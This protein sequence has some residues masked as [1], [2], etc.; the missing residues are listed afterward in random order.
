MF[1]FLERFKEKRQLQMES[2]DSHKAELEPEPNPCED[3]PHISLVELIPRAEQQLLRGNKKRFSEHFSYNLSLL[4]ERLPDAGLVCELFKAGTLSKRKIALVYLKNRANPGI[5][6]EIKDRIKAIKAETILD[7]SYVER[8]LEN[9]NASPFPQI[10]TTQRPDI[11]ESALVQGR[12]AIIVEGSPD[13]MLAP[14]TFFDLMDTPDDA[15]RRWYIAANFFRLARYIMFL[16]AA[17]LPGFYIAMTSYN[18]EMIP[19]TLLFTILASREGTPFP[20][21]FETFLMMGVVE[22]VRMMMIRIP[23]QVGATIALLTGV[24]LVGA[25]LAAN[26]I[27]APVV[28]IVTLTVISSFAIPN[29]DLRSSVRIIQ[30]FTM[31]MSSFL[32]IFGFAASFFYIA[33]HLVTLKSFGIPYMSPLAPLEASGWGHTILRDNTVTM[34]Q[35]ET[36]KPIA[37]HKDR[38]D[39][40][41]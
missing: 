25:G 29:Y 21:Y 18:P 23:S 24:T 4:T 5:V 28:M 7:S 33:I 17:S 39:K 37:N 11:A 20:V 41:E 27:A 9:S 35:D 34:A 13:V 15:Y 8:N 22:A 1:G 2:P 10:E 40:G 36:Y 30:F 14:A 32:G 16:F 38:G 12:T 31:I 26:V 6:S 19:T 3:S